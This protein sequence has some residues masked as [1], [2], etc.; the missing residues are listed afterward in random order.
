MFGKL[1]IDSSN[2]DWV[3]T[4]DKEETI[5]EMLECINT[6]VPE[7]LWVEWIF[8]H[9]FD[10]P[11]AQSQK[12]PKAEIIKVINVSTSFEIRF[13]IGEDHVHIKYNDNK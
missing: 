13:M 10:G 2:P 7:N 9:N 5:K 11:E 4:W 12:W 6:E 3:G 1:T 8:D